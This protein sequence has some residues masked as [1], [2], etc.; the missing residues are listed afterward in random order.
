MYVVGLVSS[1][2]KRSACFSVKIQDD[3]DS[4]FS[5]MVLAAI[6]IQFALL[7]STKSKAIRILRSFNS[8]NRN[9][10][11]CGIVTAIP[12]VRIQCPLRYCR[13]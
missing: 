3:R 7:T 6:L 13:N 4:F 9:N 1:N 12:S 10:I 5:R 11:K 8:T 2:R